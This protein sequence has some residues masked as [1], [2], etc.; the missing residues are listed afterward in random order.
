MMPK[1][2]DSIGRQNVIFI[3]IATM[4]ILAIALLHTIHRL[5]FTLEI[6]PD[7]P[8][9]PSVW[10]QFVAIVGLVLPAAAWI[11]Q[12][13]HPNERHVLSGYLVVLLAQIITEIVL[14]QW[15]PRGMSVVIGTLYSGFRI[16]Q[17][18]QGQQALKSPPSPQWSWMK[19]GLWVLFMIWGVNLIQFLI[20]RWPLMVEFSEQY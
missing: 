7:Q 8:L 17:L 13:H 11:L 10:H 16:V 9:L 15:F 5:P 2:L 3:A 20:F 12:R 1:M 19:V 18:W 4:V 6:A 14:L